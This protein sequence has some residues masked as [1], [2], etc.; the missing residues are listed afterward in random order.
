MQRKNNLSHFIT[1]EFL[2]SKLDSL[3]EELDNNA[4]KYKDEIL[5]KMDEVMGELGELRDENTIGSAQTSQLNS[6]VENHEER[7]KNLEKIPQTA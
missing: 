6:A 2:E 4:Q 5:T 7:I 1:K 3:K